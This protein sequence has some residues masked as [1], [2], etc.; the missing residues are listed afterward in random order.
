MRSPL[1]LES[2]QVLD[3]IER[4]G[5]FAAAALSLN[6][7]PSA[8][9]Y[10]VQKLETDLGATLFEK[11]GRRAMLTPAGAHLIEQGRQL[12]IAADELVTATR[13]VATGWEPRLRIAVDTI[14]AMDTL[15]PAIATL[16]AEHPS[17]EITLTT[18]VLGGTWEA[19]QE[20]RVDLIVGGIG[21]VP[22]R[23]GITCEHWQ[24]VRH[25]F[26]AAPNHP[27]CNAPQPLTAASIREH[28]A[29]IIRDTARN[30][31]PMSKGMLNQP[32]R[33]Y[34]STMADK[35]QAQRYGLGVGY[36]PAGLIKD[37]LAA[38]EL[39]ELIVAKPKESDLFMLAWKTSN[40]G[41][42]LH[43]LVRSLRELKAR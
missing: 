17:I 19:L 29:V 30:S 25:V 37:N 40:H 18:E 36:V 34:V 10:T 7:V 24:E 41:Q 38:G 43:R 27:L 2:L 14:V 28:R 11:Q 23:K 22:T 12:L 13:Q 3:A 1:S 6:K 4:K 32:Q 26:V 15:L 31:A 5:S 21:D 39:V 16:C 42:A 33:I 35:I 20:N 8:V 9:S